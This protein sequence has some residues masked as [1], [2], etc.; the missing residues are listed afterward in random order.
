MLGIVG[1]CV[2]TGLRFV[3]FKGFL[4][5]IQFCLL[6]F[7]DEKPFNMIMGCQHI[8]AYGSHLFTAWSTQLAPLHAVAFDGMLDGA[9]GLCEHPR[10]RCGCIIAITTAPFNS[11]IAI[12]PTSTTTLTTITTPTTTIAQQLDLVELDV[13]LGKVGSEHGDLVLGGHQVGLGASSLLCF[14]DCFEGLKDFV[15]GHIS[16]VVGKEG[17][18]ELIANWIK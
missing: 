13:G 14:V 5:G 15:L 12:A 6:L 3:G 16:F 9:V 18:N 17:I 2:I 10:A 8:H 7:F 4:F 1:I 11:L